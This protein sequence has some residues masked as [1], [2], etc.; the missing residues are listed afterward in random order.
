MHNLHVL[1]SLNC[2]SK[3]FAITDNS[4]KSGMFIKSNSLASWIVLNKAFYHNFFYPHKGYHR[5]VIRVL[6]SS[7]YLLLTYHNSLIIQK[8]FHLLITSTFSSQYYKDFKML[9]NTILE[10]NALFTCLQNSLNCFPKCFTNKDM[11]CLWS[12]IFSQ[13]KSFWNKKQSIT[14][15]FN[16]QKEYQ[17]VAVWVLFCSLYLLTTKRFLFA[18]NFKTINNISIM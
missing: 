5:E 13:V 12:H 18:V 3:F 9:H 10:L 7:P 16:L 2:F 4:F 17:R 6:F 11:V 1:N 14:T 8:G 15:F